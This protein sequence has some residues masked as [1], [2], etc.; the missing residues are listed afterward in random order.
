MGQNRVV[1]VVNGHDG[2]GSCC[3]TNAATSVITCAHLLACLAHTAVSL[4]CRVLVSA[5]SCL[6]RPA[7]CWT[8][9]ARRAQHNDI[10]LICTYTLLT[11]NSVAF[12]HCRCWTRCTRR[13]NNNSNPLFQCSHDYVHTTDPILL[14]TPTCRCWTR[15][16]RRARRARCLRCVTTS[17]SCRACAPLCALRWRRTCGE[18]GRL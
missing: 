5:L 12:N 14:P 1:A 7:R 18:P 8:R 15:C 13:A 17:R 10:P 9:C 3:C 6:L 4:L 2:E 16:A 11:A